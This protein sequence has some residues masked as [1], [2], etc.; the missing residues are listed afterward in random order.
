MSELHAAL[1]ASGRKPSMPPPAPRTLEEGAQVLFTLAGQTGAALF[2]VWAEEDEP[3]QVASGISMFFDVP[4]EAGTEG[5]LGTQREPVRV[6]LALELY[7]PLGE[8]LAT[9][10]KRGA[11]AQRPQRGSVAFPLDAADPDVVY[12]VTFRDG[13][14]GTWVTAV[15][16]DRKTREAFPAFSSLPL[17]A[18]DAAFLHALF[19]ELQGLFNGTFVLFTGERGSGR[20]TTLH[21]AMEALPDDI[22]GLAALEEPRALDPRLGIARPGQTGMVSMLRAF[23]RQDPDVVMV[24]ELRTVEDVSMLIQSAMTGHAVAGVLEAKTPDDAR[25]WVQEALPGIPVQPLIIHHT[26]DAATGARAITVHR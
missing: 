2:S 5:L 18:E 21:A 14:L 12:R 22:H 1:T 8:A 9:F 15:A 23:L 3:G 19:F 4:D 13:P 11:D 10:A 6:P 25:V 17:S 26:R 16:R 7:R 20:T 24:D